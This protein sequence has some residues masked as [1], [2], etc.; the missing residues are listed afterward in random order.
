MTDGIDTLEGVTLVI[1]TAITVEVMMTSLLVQA[2]KMVGMVPPM[3]PPMASL[4]MVMDSQL[5]PTQQQHLQLRTPSR[6]N[7]LHQ[8]QM[9]L[10][11]LQSTPHLLSLRHKQ[12][13]STP[14]NWCPTQCLLSSLSKNPYT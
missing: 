1:G 11:P 8:L 14:H 3:A 4:A 2:L 12:H 5:L 13:H 9:V 10:S 7:S 6:P